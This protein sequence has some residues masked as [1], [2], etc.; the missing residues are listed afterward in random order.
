MRLLAHVL[1]AREIALAL[2]L[3]LAPALARGIALARARARALAR[4]LDPVCGPKTV[5]AIDIAVELAR[6]RAIRPRVL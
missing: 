5:R 6:H 3:G 2:V 4:A 1:S